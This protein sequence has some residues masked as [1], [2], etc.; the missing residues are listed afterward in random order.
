MRFDP[1][2][3]N[4]AENIQ[5]HFEE[6]EGADPAPNPDARRSANT[7]ETDHDR[8]ERLAET[9]RRRDLGREG[10]ERER[11]QD[12]NPQPEQPAPQP[13]QA[14]TGLMG[15]A[16]EFERRVVEILEKIE[17]RLEKL[18]AIEAKMDQIGGLA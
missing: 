16:S 2:D 3:P 6:R 17:G 1:R 5:R 10:R 8:E 9:R 11:E 13:P 4:L 7:Y 12:R 18:D 15:P 14:P